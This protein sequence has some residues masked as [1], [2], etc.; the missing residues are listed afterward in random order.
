MK[1]LWKEAQGQDLAEYGLIVVP[2]ALVA[3][4]S[5]TTVGACSQRC[6]FKR[7]RKLYGGNVGNS[8]RYPC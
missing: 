1:R 8:I 7:Y 4:A 6:V 2:I 5:V 3:I